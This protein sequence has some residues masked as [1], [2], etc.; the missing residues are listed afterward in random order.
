MGKDAFGNLRKARPVP[1]SLED[2]EQQM[3]C[4]SPTRRMGD[5]GFEGRPGGLVVLAGKSY[6]TTQ[7]SNQSDRCSGSL[8]A[9]ELLIGFLQSL[10]RNKRLHTQHA[11]IGVLIMLKQ[12]ASR[13]GERLFRPIQNQE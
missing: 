3:R 4:L 7:A 12:P 6:L 8:Q 1:L 9:V 13:Y 11:Q 2:G 5:C 10:A